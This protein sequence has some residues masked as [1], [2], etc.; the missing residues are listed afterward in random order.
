M[1]TIIICHVDIRILV[2]AGVWKSVSA[3]TVGRMPWIALFHIIHKPL[4][5]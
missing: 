3:H 1:L 4:K 2:N 5:Y